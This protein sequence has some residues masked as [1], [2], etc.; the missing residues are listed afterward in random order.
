VL[1]YLDSCVVIYLIE[2]AEPWHS[3]IRARLLPPTASASEICVSDLTRLECRVG[4]LARGDAQ[5]L[6]E[7]DE[8][9]AMPALRFAALDGRT[10]DLATELRARHRVGVPDA[11]HLAAAICAGCD[12]F[13]TNDLRLEKAAGGR[14]RIVTMD[15]LP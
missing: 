15:T 1:V 5:A 6:A 12:E 13:W 3:Q 8:F 11:L 14:V 2:L 10:F 4:P 7:Y 9:F